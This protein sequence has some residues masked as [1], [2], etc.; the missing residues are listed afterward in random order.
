M[1]ELRELNM[2][3]ELPAPACAT[4]DLSICPVGVASTE[5]TVSR[6]RTIGCL[7]ERGA[8]VPSNL[9]PPN[10]R[11]RRS[12]T[13]PASPSSSLA[14]PCSLLQAPRYTRIRPPRDLVKLEDRLRLLLEPPLESLLAARQ[15][16]FARPP[17]G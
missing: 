17:F 15:L 12:A 5:F 13:K 6:S 8:G 11:T 9:L 10:V 1:C 14:A 16:D 7:F 4:I 2:E 3:L